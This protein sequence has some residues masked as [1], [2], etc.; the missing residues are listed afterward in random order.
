MLICVLVATT[1]NSCI[2]IFEAKMADQRLARV[3]DEYARALLIGRDQSKGIE[4]ADAALE[5]ANQGV[6]AHREIAVSAVCLE[7]PTC[8]QTGGA[9]KLSA[10][11]Q[12]R[13]LD[14]LI[15]IPSS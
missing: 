4:Y 2:P 1:L 8:L 12:N 6:E 3:L 7:N 5:L 15:E 10:T 11:S 9:L 14:A 13:R